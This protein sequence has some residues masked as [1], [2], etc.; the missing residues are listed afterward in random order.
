MILWAIA[1]FMM[2]VFIYL[3]MFRPEKQ[4]QSVFRYQTLDDLCASVSVHMRDRL[5]MQKRKVV[6]HDQFINEIEEKQLL[7]RTLEKAIGGCYRSRSVILDEIQAFLI[8]S[9]M[10][11]ETLDDLSCVLFRSPDAM[12]ANEKFETMLY[13]MR[14][15]IYES[16]TIEQLYDEDNDDLRC[17]FKKFV[18]FCEVFQQKRPLKTDPGLS[19]YYVNDKD[20]SLHFR[21]YMEERNIEITVADAV[22]I[23]SIL[24]Y[25][26]LYGFGIVD[27]IAYDNSID[28]IQLGTTGATVGSG[29]HVSAP[30][31][32]TLVAISN[33]TI[34]LQCISFRNE[35]AFQ[36][37][38]I[39]LA[40][41]G[42]KTFT[43]DDG[44]KYTTLHDLRRVTARRPPAS[45]KFAVN[46]RRLSA[47]VVTNRQLLEMNP[48]VPNNIQI[49]QDTLQVMA[50]TMTTFCWT[51]EQGSGKTSHVN[52]FCN[53]LDADVGIRA[54]GNIDETQFGNRY[55]ERDAQH[56]FETPRQSLH[57]IAG[58][59]RR[60]RGTY[61][62]LMEVID[63]ASGQEAINNFKSGYIGGMMTGHG[64]TTESMVEF[65]AQLLA[66]GQATSTVETTKIVASVLK[67]N[68][69][70]AKYGSTFHYEA[71][72]EIIPREWK[73]NWELVH[74]DIEDVS[75]SD[76][77][78]NYNRIQ[79]YNDQL[80]YQNALN[81]KLFEASTVIRFNKETLTYE[82]VN[83]PSLGLCV[84]WFFAIDPTRRRFLFD[85][86]QTYFKVDLAQELIDGK[87]VFVD[88]KEDLL[89][90]GS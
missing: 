57:A 8:G 50:W 20:L 13:F 32:S 47:D 82:A 15:E 65:M 68:V 26:D 5:Y 21:R 46:I 80:Y 74:P 64:N 14:K 1:I 22:A 23:T 48:V 31:N 4:V 52:A 42:E 3:L 73:V 84:Q 51:G 75:Y 55:P 39:A 30:T 54:L 2:M 85:Y 61:L 16:L 90:F 88:S 86:L 66:M 69:K 41:N 59:G 17:A 27:T 12:L 28:E 83:R 72:T 9:S 70:T 60:T 33:K 37:A 7:R 19:G 36:N 45:D 29:R 43:A 58:L 79:A 40:S 77:D 38:I 78:V 24:I 63:A 81:P 34:R 49:V 44:Y 71:M 53:L 10:S 87:F 89:K 11:I 35:A 76:V 18:Q 25:Q 56:L 62:V 6:S 67:M